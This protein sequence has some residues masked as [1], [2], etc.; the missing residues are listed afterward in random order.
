MA[1]DPSIIT[2]NDIRLF[3]LDRTSEDN[4]L[5]DDVEFTQDE[6]EY[7]HGLAVAKYN[8]TLPILTP[9]TEIARYEAIIGTCAILM[10]MK[11]I[12]L[13]RNKL[14]YTNK[15]GTAIQDKAKAQE[16]LAV[17]TGL[18]NEFDQ[19]TK[20]LKIS[21]NIE[22]GYGYQSSPYRFVGYRW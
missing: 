2:E 4:F 10:R 3:M 15:S 8:S 6:I 11:A 21:L 12:N 5:L 1:I 17:G 13:L 14:D 22:S 20:M 16:Y 18:M 9:V 7:A 19:R